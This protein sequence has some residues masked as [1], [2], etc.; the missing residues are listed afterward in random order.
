MLGVFAR[1]LYKEKLLSCNLQSS[2]FL[3]GKK[4]IHYTTE[5]KAVYLNGKADVL[6]RFMPNYFYN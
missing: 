5:I 3:E 6:A 1:I 4:A 2:T